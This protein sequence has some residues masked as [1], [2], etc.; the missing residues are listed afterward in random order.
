MK[1]VIIY[2]LNENLNQ[3]KTNFNFHNILLSFVI[4]EMF[5]PITFIKA[6]D[7]Q[8]RLGNVQKV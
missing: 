3:P 4:F 5:A 2:T 6:F 1:L 7:T 8:L